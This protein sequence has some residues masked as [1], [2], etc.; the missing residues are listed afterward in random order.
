MKNF[1]SMIRR[2]AWVATGILSAGLLLTSCLKDNDDFNNDTP[3][4]GLMAFNL[5]PDVSAAG[6][7]ISGNNLTSSPL[8]FN[9]FTG[10][11]LAIF[12]GSRSVEA[13]SYNSGNTLATGNGDF[14][15]ERYYSVFLVGSDSSFSNVIVEDKLD[16]L[17]GAGKAFVRYINAVPDASSPAVT[18]N[19]N[20]TDVVNDN[21]AFKSVSE[22]VAIDPGAATVTV[23]NGGTINAT[24]SITFE[25]QKIYTIL[26]IGEPGGSG[27]TAVQVKYIQNGEIDETAERSK[28]ASTRSVN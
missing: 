19:V 18:V 4:A 6:F 10:T 13:F 11:Y 27:E 9:S 14:Q 26:L 8:G 20:G 25:Q 1:F 23:S 28:A 21:A 17:A 5:S 15:A 24:R 12:P 7:S 2:Q 22:F 16:T 3:V